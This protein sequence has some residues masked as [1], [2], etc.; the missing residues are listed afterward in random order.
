V[1]G[2]QMVLTDAGIEIHL[3][4]E[5]G[6]R[7]AMEQRIRGRLAQVHP[8]LATA[9]FIYGNDLQPTRAGKRRW[10]VDRRTTSSCA[11]SQAS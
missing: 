11:A 6:D 7:A 3:V 2:I 10:Y 4:A 1:H 9:T 5:A 8:A